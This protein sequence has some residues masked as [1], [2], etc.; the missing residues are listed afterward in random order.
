[1]PESFVVTSGIDRFTQALEATTEAHEWMIPIMNTYLLGNRVLWQRGRFKRALSAP[2]LVAELNPRIIST[3]CVLLLRKWLRRPSIVWG[4]SRS[5]GQRSSLTRRLRFWQ[6]QFA[7]AV[8]AYTMQQ[9]AEFQK[10]LPEKAIFVAP[11][12]C[13][14]IVDCQ[15]AAGCCRDSIVYVGRLVAD[16]KLPLLLK[17]FALALERL[18]EATRLIIVG[19]GPMEQE[20]RDEA[21][22]LAVEDRV[23]FRGYV[24]NAAE[25]SDIYARALC[26]VSPGYVGLT[27]VQAIARGVPMIV[28]RTEYHSPEIEVCV[29]GE[30]ARFFTSDSPED[31]ARTLLE[32][33][34]E[35]E[36]WERKRELLCHHIKMTYTYQSMARAFKKMVQTMLGEDRSNAGNG[37]KK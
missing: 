31:L 33:H 12:A 35:S 27:A 36:I 6:S 1:M 15:A 9:A 11:N 18:P 32:V 24:S 5:L 14:D 26:C 22:H 17:G 34:T 28:G 19:E 30:T 37:Q 16:K 8:L 29:D 20:L 25:I 10:M 2:L 7:D 21:A 4:H 23:V 3:W 13:V